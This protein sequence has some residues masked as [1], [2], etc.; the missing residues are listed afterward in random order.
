MKVLIKIIAIFFLLRIMGGYA[1]IMPS[2]FSARLT[3]KPK[4]ISAEAQMIDIAS[5]DSTKDSSF[6]YHEVELGND[7]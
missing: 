7:D 4:M 3:E 2:L 5:V 6:I 1:Q